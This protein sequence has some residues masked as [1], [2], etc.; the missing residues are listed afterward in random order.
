MQSR[1]WCIRWVLGYVCASAA[2]LHAES[3]AA[4]N[5]ENPH[6]WEP[7][8]KSVAV[9]KNGLGY[10]IREGEVLPREG[11]C[12]AGEMPAATLGTFSV[13]ARDEGAA[14]DIVGAGPGEVVAFDDVDAPDTGDARRTRLENHRGLNVE[15]AY[16]AKGS[17]RT[18]S[19]AIVS[20]G[21]T[22]VVLE[23]ES[24]SFAVPIA[25]IA[26][27][28]LLD[29]PLRVHVEGL[30]ES[31]DVRTTLG[32]GYLRNG[33]RWVPEYSLRIIDETTA[34][35]TLR[36]TLVNDAED[37]IDC[38]V[39]FVIGAPN[40]AD[41]GQLTPL[42]MRRLMRAMDAAIPAQMDNRFS[43]GSAVVQ[44]IG[45]Q[46][47]GQGGFVGDGW[48][49]AAMDFG[50][51]DHAAADYAV[52]T[53]EGLTVRR[54]ESAAVTLFTRPVEYGHIYRW[55]PPANIRHHL[56]LDNTGATPWTTGPCLAVSGDRPLSEAMLRYTPR[57]GVAEFPVTDAIN[58][59][60]RQQE[61]E[62]DREFKAYS[63]S[64]DRSL[65]LVRLEGTLTLASHESE[66]VTLSI[67]LPIP[68]KPIAASDKGTV[69]LHTDALSLSERRGSIAWT[70]E[71]APGKTRTL[72]YAYERHVES[73]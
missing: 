61:R 9:F 52:Y 39:H 18:A 5:V 48:A 3:G 2:L 22:H 45:G 49:L 51:D 64:N 7:T 70:V 25:G 44:A 34:E 41:A 31:G 23:N 26:R 12:V 28:Q 57:G 63:I 54:G 21:D 1:S 32:M 20:L 13:Y 30:A 53:K 73:K 15:L 38:D 8:T 16:T 58:I 43:N 29:H 35:L 68:G 19:G 14:V 60:H 47:G 66:P 56:L 36:G 65:D 24:E 69:G 4:P 37:L 33:I 72:T 71:V 27:M 59:T 55:C 40:F 10:F 62:A 46:E 17:E 6:V 67:D 50:M 11:W 42:A